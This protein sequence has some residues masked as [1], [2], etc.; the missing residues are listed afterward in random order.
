MPTWV[1]P[2]FTGWAGE[3][4]SYTRSGQKIHYAWFTNAGDLGS[5]T[6]IISHELVES[7]TDPDGSGFLGINRTCHGPGWCEIADICESTWASID[8]ITVHKYWSNQD[9]ACIAPS[10][11]APGHLSPGARHLT[12]IGA[13]ETPRWNRPGRDGPPSLRVQRRWPP[14][15]GSWRRACARC[16]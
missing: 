9:N 1:T 4:H 8:G 5:I 3:H 16:G 12:T 13:A 7:A 10:S 11:H 15:R 14:A 6:A 2:G